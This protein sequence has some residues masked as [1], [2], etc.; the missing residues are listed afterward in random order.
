[1]CPCVHILRSV[2]SPGPTLRL[3]VASGQEVLAFGVWLLS[4]WLLEG[5]KPG[6]KD[7]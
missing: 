6:P 7:C 5:P 1:M 2:I 3:P 4:S